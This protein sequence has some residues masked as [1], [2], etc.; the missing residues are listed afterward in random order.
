V[1][2]TTDQPE[3]PQYEARM[4]WSLQLHL[5]ADEFTF[6][7]PR[8]ALPVTFRPMPGVAAAKP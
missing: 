2:T 7:P 8:N 1:I 6:T 3:Q 5:A 4:T